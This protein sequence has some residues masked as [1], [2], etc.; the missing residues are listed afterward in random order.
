[1]P[2][3]EDVEQGDHPFAHLEDPYPWYDQIRRPPFYSQAFGGWLVTRFEDIC[4]ILDRPALFSAKDT[5]NPWVPLSPSVQATLSEGVP[6][7]PAVQNSDGA[8]HQRL[9]ALVEQALIPCFRGIRP[10][11]KAQANALVDTFLLDGHA[12]LMR[13]FALP[14][15]FLT[16]C[17]LL[18]IPNEERD[19]FR[20]RCDETLALFASTVSLSPLPEDRQQAYATSFVAL[21][22]DLGR[23]IQQ[24]QNT[25][26]SDIISA[27]LL[28]S[29]PGEPSLREEE[30]IAVLVDILFGGYKTIASLIGNS[31]VLLL[32]TPDAWPELRAHPERI[33][34]ALEE[35][36]R[37]DSPVPGQVRTTT[38]EVFLP[39][40]AEPVP[41]ET[42]VLLLYAAGNRDPAQFPHAIEF[43]L[44]RKPNQHLAFGQGIHYCVGAPLARLEGQ[45]ALET[46][47]ER[48]PNLRLAGGQTLARVPT[49]MYRAYERLEVE[50]SASPRPFR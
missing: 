28:A 39:G 14:L 35:A 47:M 2:G 43:D 37:Y 7:V 12:D 44:R 19:V 16:L 20:Q 22:H 50:W 18:A 10:F 24:R 15:P 49:L 34:L 38:Q 45:V 11:L 25:P 8:L 41:A 9:R 6:P 36:L 40:T 17:E 30:L 1:M 5:M 27:L 4:W 23:L 31:V 29:L 32:Q 3:Q 48:L 42:L 46:L 26:G 13:Q 33:A 21:Q